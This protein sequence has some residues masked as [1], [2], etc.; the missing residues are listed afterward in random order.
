M[1]V[2]SRASSLLFFTSLVVLGASAAAAAAAA[3]PSH[4]VVFLVDDLGYGDTGHRGAEFPTTHIDALALGSGGVVLNQ[5]YVMQLCSPTRGSILTSR[6]SYNIGMD[7][8]VLTGGDARCANQ[9]VAFLG[10][11][12]VKNGVATAFIGKYDAGYSAWKCT[13]NCRGFDYW[14]GYYGAAEDYYLHG[15]GKALDFHE[16]YEQA[17][18]YVAKRQREGDIGEDWRREEKSLPFGVLCVLCVLYMCACGVCVCVRAG[19]CVCAKCAE[20]HV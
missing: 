4:A 8:N 2:L 19:V 10:D 11:Q 18:Q 15:S 14:L 20:E 16:N 3:S 12:M 5:S 13:P 6:Y 17:P 7:G 1:K 9:S